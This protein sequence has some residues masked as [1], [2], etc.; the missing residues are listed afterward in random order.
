MRSCFSQVG[1]IDY[2]PLVVAGSSARALA[3]SR[4]TNCCEL[5]LQFLLAVLQGLKTELP[6]VKLDTELVDIACYFSA[7]RFVFFELML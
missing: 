3:S 7:L 1:A 4:A 6:A 2:S 5:G